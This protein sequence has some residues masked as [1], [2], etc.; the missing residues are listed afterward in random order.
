M[1]HYPTLIWQMA[2]WGRVVPAF[3]RFSSGV[4]FCESG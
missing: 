3:R 1:R 2:G 4:V